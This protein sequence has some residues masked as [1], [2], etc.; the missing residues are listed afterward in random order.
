MSTS[1]R[2]GGQKPV[3]LHHSTAQQTQELSKPRS[4]GRYK[5]LQ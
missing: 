1:P 2:V 4:T 3:G 5:S